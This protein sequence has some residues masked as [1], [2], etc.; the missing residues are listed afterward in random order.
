MKNFTEYGFAAFIFAAWNSVIIIEMMLVPA[1]WKMKISRFLAFCI[2][3]I[4]STSAAINGN[5]GSTVFPLVLFGGYIISIIVVL[6]HSPRLKGVLLA[7]ILE[8]LGTQILTGV[9]GMI[10]AE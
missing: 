8:L 6:C 1:A 10:S 7:L 5:S 2:T 3:V 9:L 4:F